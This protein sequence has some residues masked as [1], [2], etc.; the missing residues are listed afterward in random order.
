MVPYGVPLRRTG[1]IMDLSI[2]IP[3]YN[4]ERRIALTLGRTCDFLAQRSWAAE[5]IVVDD[6]SADRTAATVAE[7]AARRE[8]PLPRI[9]CLSNGAN[10]GKGYTVRHGVD[11]AVGACVGFMDADYKTDVTGL[12]QVLELLDAGWDGVVGDRTAVATRIAVPRRRYRELGSRAFKW[13]LR[14]SMGLGEFPDTQCGFK[15]FR[16]DVARELFSLQQIDGFMF[17]VELLVLAGRRGY[18]IACMPVVWSDDPDS[19]FKPLSGSIRNLVELLRIR[20]VHR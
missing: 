14:M 20:W 15:F 11:A 19:R 18:R 10:R 2:V 16:A 1:T 7:F 4:E 17:D 3:A 13:L 8:Q 5:L 9:H 12:D 6:G